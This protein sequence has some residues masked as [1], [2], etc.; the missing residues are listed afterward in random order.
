[1]VEFMK[2]EH[3]INLLLIS[4]V[5]IFMIFSITLSVLYS[6]KKKSYDYLKNE[7]NKYI[8]KI[9]QAELEGNI[10]YI[11]VVNEINDYINELNNQ[12]YLLENLIVEQKTT[13]NSNKE[14]Q[15]LI[16]NNRILIN[17]ISTTQTEIN[18]NIQ[19]LNSA[20]T[21]N[22]KNILNAINNQN[23][24]ISNLINNYN[25]ISVKFNEVESKLSGNIYLIDK[26]ENSQINIESYIDN[27]YSRIANIHC[28]GT[29]NKINIIILFFSIMF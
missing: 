26:I 24:Q 16:Y 2:I 5:V 8:T 4:L 14:I 1:M 10:N 13:D 29:I 28:N 21:S 20:E 15:S 19:K 9:T 3:K 11:N 12:T 25:K 23:N 17:N 27:I 6:K 18:K 7:Y 22:N